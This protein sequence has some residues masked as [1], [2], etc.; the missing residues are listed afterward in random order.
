MYNRAGLT[1]L[2]YDRGRSS[3][4]IQ[5]KAEFRENL[6]VIGR[7]CGKKKVFKKNADEH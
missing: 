1:R 3:Y 5:P 7:F 4:L 6:K 2:T